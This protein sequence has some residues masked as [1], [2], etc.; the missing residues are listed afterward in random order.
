MSE[1]F[2]RSAEKNQ[3]SLHD[4]L[5][6]CKQNLGQSYPVLRNYRVSHPFFQGPVLFQTVKKHAEIPKQK[7]YRA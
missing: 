7:S 1:F 2:E 6:I 5:R 4:S 3:F